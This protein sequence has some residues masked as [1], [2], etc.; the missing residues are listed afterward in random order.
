[1]N[2][3]NEK[4]LLKFKSNTDETTLSISLDPKTIVLLKKV[5][6][7]IIFKIL[8]NPPK[9]KRITSDDFN[10]KQWWDWRQLPDAE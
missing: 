10:Q 2:L 9:N 1:M 4:G 3:L 7:R 6:N 5:P 8:K